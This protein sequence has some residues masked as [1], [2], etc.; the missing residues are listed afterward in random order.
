VYS[1]APWGALQSP[2]GDPEAECAAVGANTV[3]VGHEFQSLSNL[4]AAADAGD[5]IQLFTLVE[6]RIGNS[7]L[8]PGSRALFRREAGGQSVEYVTGLTTA[9]R[10]QYRRRNQTNFQN[11]VNGVGNLANIEELR[12]ILEA[13][14]PVPGEAEPESYGWE[15]RIPLRNVP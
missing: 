9:S 13:E 7:L 8:R 3:G 11:M 14:A 5:I 15:F 1:I 4:T 12:V 6:Y 2:S 10:F